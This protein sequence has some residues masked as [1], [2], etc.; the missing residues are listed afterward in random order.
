MNELQTQIEKQQARYFSA[1]ERVHNARERAAE[2][3]KE[4]EEARAM[5]VALQFAQE[6]M[7]KDE[8]QED[9][10]KDSDPSPE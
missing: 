10:H 1:L 5:V 6:Q 7:R 9:G 3:E 8:S 2:A 4:L